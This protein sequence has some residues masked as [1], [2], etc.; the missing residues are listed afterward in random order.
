MSIKFSRPMYSPWSM[1]P[2]RSR[3][4]QRKQTNEPAA[5]FEILTQPDAMGE[6][7]TYNE[8]VKAMTTAEFERLSRFI[9]THCG[10]KMPPVKKIMLE[11]RLQKRLRLLGVGSFRDY[12]DMLFGSPGGR[13]EL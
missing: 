12:C 3:R 5:E 4:K 8:S 6:N 9:Y 1:M 10:I 13:E 2:G 7:K 11:S